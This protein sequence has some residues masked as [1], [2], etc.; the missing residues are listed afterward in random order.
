VTTG[1]AAA[2]QITKGKLGT[3]RIDIEQL[4]IFPAVAER[5]VMV[6]CSDQKEGLEGLKTPR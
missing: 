6:I 1:A 4:P 2:I 5:Q 3:S